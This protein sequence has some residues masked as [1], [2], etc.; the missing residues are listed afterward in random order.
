V[1]VKA[2]PKAT[3]FYWP[4]ATPE[5][6]SQENADRN[7]AYR[8]Q[9]FNLPMVQGGE[10]PNYLSKIDWYKNYYKNEQ[11]Y[12]QIQMAVVL[13]ELSPVLLAA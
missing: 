5:Q 7:L 11:E 2:K 10:S 8:R 1:V 4:D 6:V 3:V 12:R 9:E 13:T